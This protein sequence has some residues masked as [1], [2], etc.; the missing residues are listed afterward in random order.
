MNVASVNDAPVLDNSGTMTLT[1]ITED[2]TNNSGQTVASIIA[3]A[4][5]DR[6]TDVDSGAVEGIAIT[7]LSSGNG[8]WQYSLDG[9]NWTNVGTVSDSSSLLLRSTDFIRFVPNAQNATSGDMTFRAWDQTT[10]TFG[11]KVDASVNGAN[12]S[13]STATE[14]ASI[15]VTAVNDAPTLGFIGTIG[16]TATNEDTTSAATLVS[17]ILISGVRGDV[18][19]SALSGIAITSVS[20]SGTFQ[21]S[22]DGVTWTDFGSVSSA[23]SLLLTSTSSVRF[24][25]NGNN[26]ESATFTYRAWDRTSGTASING[27]PG[28]ADSNSNGG[29]TA[30]SS[31]SGSVLC[32]VSNVNDAPVL[33]NTGTMT[34]T[35][36]T[37]DQTTNSGQTVASIITSASGDRITDVD[38]SPV[39]GI[40]I[41]ATTNGNGS[42]EYSTNGGTSWTSV[43]TVA[44]NS[45]LLLRSTDML[46]F[47]P[48]GQNA[49]TG[50]I[51]FRAWDQTSGTFGT[52]V[53]ASTNGGATAFS[54]AT[55]VASITVTSVNDAPNAVFDTATAVEAGGLNNGTT[56]TNPTGNVLTNDTD[57]DAGD[58]KTVIGVA[59]GT[60]G[61]ASSN[62]AANV[63]GTYGSINIAA[64]GT[65]TYTVDNNN[66]S[67]QALRTSANT[68]T[69]VFTYTMRDTAGLTS[70][71]QFTVTIQGANDAPTDVMAATYLSTLTP[72]ASN[73]TYSGILND[74]D[75]VSNPLV[76]DGVNFARGLGMHAPT[77]GVSTADYAINGAT[78]FKATIGI[79]DY[80]TG[81][82]G[83][84]VFRVYVDNVLQYTSSTLSSTSVPIDLSIN[85]N[86]GTTLRLEVDNAGN[87]NAADHAVWFNARLEG[88]STG[89]S[90][91]EN[92][93]NGTVVG[94]VNRTDTD[95][96]DNSTYTLID[97]AGGR[98][99]INNTTGLIT[100]AN[101]SLL[102]FEASTTHTIIVRATD[103][104]GLTFD[105]SMT[106]NVTNVNEAPTA[107]SDNANAIE[108]GGT[109]NGT[110]GSNPTGNVLTNDSD[111]DAGDTRT[112]T[113]VSAGV[114]A[115]ATGSVAAP[116]NGA[117]G[118]ITIA[119]DGTYT[120][121]V[122]NN[123]ASVQALR[124]PGD[125]LTEVFTYTITD[126]GGLTSTT[127]LTITIGGANDAP[128]Q[129]AIE[130]TTLAY[131]ENDGAVAIT[132]TLA[133]NDVDDANIASAV[134]TITG[135]YAVGQDLLAFTNQNGIT[136]SWNATT[137]ELT[138]TGSATK[139][140]YQAAL[141][142]I[143][144]QN[145]SEAPSTATRTVT[146]TVND[147]GLN[148]NSQTRDIQV[149]TVNDAPVLNNAGTMTLTLITEDDTNNVGNTVA[150]IIASASGNR[151]TDADSAAIEGIAITALNSIYGKWQYSLDN[152]TSWLDVGTVSNA[153]ALL[154]RS[155]D[156]IR[157]LPQFE[158]GSTPDLTFRAWDQTSGTAGS[159]VTTVTNGGTTAFSSATETA[160]IVVTDVNDAPVL[161]ASRT[162]TLSSVNEDAGVPVGAVGT[163]VSSLV[164]F[165]L[166]AGQ[167]DNVADDDISAQ[168]GVAITGTNSTSGTWY[169]STDNGTTWS[170]M[171]K[172]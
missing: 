13:F 125:T 11:T 162:P 17:D 45:A 43:G 118:S 83:S 63:S 147:S 72:T 81:T 95:W 24:I 122:D 93:A 124:G 21:Y 27:T 50:D 105:K 68:L 37:E 23:N 30:F 9:T 19:S 58:T 46:R 158:N 52:K 10:G 153:S 138:L 139:A 164:D 154:L 101:G 20:A 39:E 34:L 53:D 70:T 64:D 15:T 113:G 117:Y 133:I 156:S 77:S 120:Y 1:S 135:N 157:Y 51:T 145:S 84:V 146:F 73:N 99:S 62:V 48:N 71:A 168:L 36:I 26:G 116:V 18:D 109:A 89:L 49:T 28:Y 92:A 112:V 42:W 59:A 115:S 149:T 32:F 131:S 106:V 108:A 141:R 80:T 76:L 167:V 38:T 12:T 94:S 25:P 47:I 82:F 148:S 78:S 57:V 100:V 44:G 121:T 129:S 55:E 7:T 85:T 151:I 163:L 79:N 165:Q 60:V 3:S 33:D 16:M 150:D 87:G 126:A 98:F 5:G 14:V 66:A 86:G 170:A 152:G 97:D 6:I 56:G 29:T 128:T 91:A 35:S 8:T 172:C 40:A 142:S 90:I 159:K 136:G 22:T 75:H 119:S 88:G 96:G 144:Y 61:S 4:G 160:S 155:T 137:G 104:G 67:V 143:T 107:T 134:V 171:G 2:Q 140:Q 130:G 166:P 103:A 123:N 114:Q 31:Q 169:Y 74:V 132:S 110:V 65:Y 54:S 111:V 127:Q 69:D 102:N 161:N 41:T